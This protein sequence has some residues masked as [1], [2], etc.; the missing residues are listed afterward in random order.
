M[1]VVRTVDS[2]ISRQVM[3]LKAHLTCLE[4]L[5]NIWCQVLKTVYGISQAI[6]AVKKSL[7]IQGL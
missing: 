1:E 3:F 7:L 5:N 4:A 2:S 6:E